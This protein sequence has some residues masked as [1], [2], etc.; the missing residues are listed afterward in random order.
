M[1]IICEGK[2]SYEIGDEPFT[3]YIDYRWQILMCLGCSEINIFQYSSSSLWEYPLD[4]DFF[5]SPEEVKRLYPFSDKKK[6]I[7]LKATNNFIERV[8]SDVEILLSKSGSVSGVDRIHAAFHAYLRL[9]CE[10]SEISTCKDDSI[11]KLFKLLCQQHSSFRKS[12]N[13]S[14]INRLLKSFAGI[15][16]SLN[17]IRNRAS[18]AHPSE[19]LLEEEE[20][21][22]YIDVIRTL[23]VYLDRK[24][25]A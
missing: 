12:S 5:A 10:R 7:A 3:D 6:N 20:A 17:P 14:D 19:N 11:T 18:T 15:I 8:I 25:E 22:L 9:V 2:H 1:S 24:L 21:A 23:L 13:H 16:D 4:G